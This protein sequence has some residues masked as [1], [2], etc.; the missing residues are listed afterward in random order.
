MVGQAGG[1]V[2]EQVQPRTVAAG[3]VGCLDGLGELDR[4][5]VEVAGDDEIVLAGT[6]RL[7]GGEDVVEVGDLGGDGGGVAVGRCGAIGGEQE[8]DARPSEI[9]GLEAG[10][11]GLAQETIR[12]AAASAAVAV[13]RAAEC[14]PP[15]ARAHAIAAIHDGIV[16][17]G[18]AGDDSDAARR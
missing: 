17:G 6:R 11:G 7:H 12:G 9:A 8:I 3:A 4:L 15:G 13:G 18:L 1:A 2:A 5:E 14:V 10:E 16:L